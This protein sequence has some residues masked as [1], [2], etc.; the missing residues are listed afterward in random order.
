VILRIVNR[1]MD[2]S[3]YDALRA[4]LDIDRRHPLGL[5]LH[6]AAE[7]NGKMQVAQIWESDWYARKFDEET[8]APALAEL[9]ITGEAKVSVFELEHLVTP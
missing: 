3:T 7:V 1:G 6:G 2:R 5:H 8:L 4:R 9:G